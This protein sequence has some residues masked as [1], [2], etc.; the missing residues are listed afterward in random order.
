[1]GRPSG[2]MLF[3]QV[4]ENCNQSIGPEGPPA[5]AGSIGRESPPTKTKRP[6]SAGLFA[7]GAGPQI[8]PMNRIASN[9]P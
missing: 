4:A 5:K 6:A 7:S 1:M 8:Q 2:P 3:A 9:K